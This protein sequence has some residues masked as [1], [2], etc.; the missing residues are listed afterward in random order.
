MFGVR[1][2]SDVVCFLSSS[3]ILGVGADDVVDPAAEAANAC[4]QCRRG[5]VGAA[6]AP[7][8]HSCQHPPAGLGVTQQAAAGV[9]AATFAAAVDRAG[10]RGAA[11]AHGAVAGEAVAVALLALPR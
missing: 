5:G 9:A 6:V 8:N 3:A 11:G 2:M 4:V 10:V 7:G 1:V